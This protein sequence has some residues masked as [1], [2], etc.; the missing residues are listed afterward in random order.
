MRKALYIISIIIACATNS[1]STQNISTPQGE[2]E[3]RCVDLGLSVKW[4]T[5]NIC[6][7]KEWEAGYHFAWG[8][9]VTKAIC[10]WD[11]Y[12][13]GKETETP[14]YRTDTLGAIA[15]LEDADDVVAKLWKGGWRMPSWA[16]VLELR[17]KCKWERVTLK[18]KTNAYKVTGPNGNYIYIPCGGILKDNGFVEQNEVY[19]WSKDAHELSG[20]KHSEMAFAISSASS[21][22]TLPRYYGVCIR[23]VKK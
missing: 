22:T 17:D 8:E 12:S 3:H 15:T 7:D 11:N 9:T 16:E 10:T 21:N 4:A 14:R 20:D 19:L 6:A 1:C 5:M 18:H 2:D 13:L 23:G